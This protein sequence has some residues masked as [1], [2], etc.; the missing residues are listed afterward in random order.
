[1]EIGELV[2]LLQQKRD[3]LVRIRFDVLRSLFA[4]LQSSR[5]SRVGVYLKTLN[6]ERLGRGRRSPPAFFIACK[7][8]FVKIACRF[9]HRKRV[10]LGGLPLRR[11]KGR[12]PRR[13]LA[14]DFLHLGQVEAVHAQRLQVGG[15]G[16]R[17]SVHPKKGGASA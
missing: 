7:H 4:L 5:E 17:G 3:V 6:Q 1:G 2:V 16:S 12:L 11:N 13:G 8:A 15:P 9:D 10:G 14:G